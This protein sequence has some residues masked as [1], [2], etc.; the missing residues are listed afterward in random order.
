[1]MPVMHR[2]SILYLPLVHLTRAYRAV[3]AP[4]DCPEG[5]LT[6]HSRGGT[7]SYDVFE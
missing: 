6:T 1:M 3:R 5:P 4:V 7:T 2:A